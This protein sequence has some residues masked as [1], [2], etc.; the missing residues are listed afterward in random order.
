MSMGLAADRKTNEQGMP[1]IL[2][3]AMMVKRYSHVIRLSKPSFLVQ[4]VLFSILT[5][6]ALLSGY[7]AIYK[8]YLN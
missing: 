8:K 1:N 2:Q 4:S 7:K 6:I 3:V 5:P